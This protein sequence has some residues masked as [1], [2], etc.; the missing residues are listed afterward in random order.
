MDIRDVMTA[1]PDV[2]LAVEPCARAAHLMRQRKC[3]FVPIVDSYATM[4]VIGVVTDR[5]IAMFLSEVEVTATQV[6]LERCMTCAPAT[7]VSEA[8][9]EEAATLMGRMGVHR[10]PVVHDGRLVGVIAMKDLAAAAG[11]N[12]IAH[13]IGAERATV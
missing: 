10:L 4:R 12:G 11:R 1:D 2:C 8:T 9:C 5:D 3:G 13:E 6:P 7:I